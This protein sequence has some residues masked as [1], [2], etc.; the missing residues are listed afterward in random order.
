VALLRAKYRRVVSNRTL[1]AGFTLLVLF[2]TCCRPGEPVR[3]SPDQDA[4]PQNTPPSTAPAAV[5]A[6]PYEFGEDWFSHNVPVWRQVLGPLSG[7]PDLRY[8]EV[9]VYEGRSFFWILENVLTHP[10][11]RLTG[12]DIKLW[13]RLQPN[14]EASGESHRIELLIG[15]S[16]TALRNLPAESFDLIYI[17]GSHTADDVLADSVLSWQ[18]LK[19]GGILIFDDYAWAGGDFNTGPVP[20]APELLPAVAIDAFVASYRYEIETLHAGYQLM[21]RKT[22]NPCDAAGI[23][24]HC[25]PLGRYLYDW[26]TRRILFG[27]DLTREVEVSPEEKALIEAVLSAGGTGRTLREREGL[28]ALN[29]KLQLGW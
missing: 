9:G 7:Q 17:D 23:K 2:L 20:P 15:D 1:A 13:P 27:D 29:E 26:S 8:L 19:D 18:L 25:S 21:V 4:R 11:A 28:A 5:Y 14:V 16:K 10:T 6:A 22:P 24:R 12:I 3:P